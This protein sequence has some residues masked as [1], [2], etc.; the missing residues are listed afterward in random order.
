MPAHAPA[1][2]APRLTA[3]EVRSGRTVTMAA[4][5]ETERGPDDPEPCEHVNAVGAASSVPP[6]VVVMGVSGA[7]K[8][9]VGRL[10]A[11]RLGLPFAEA[12]D[13][14]SAA[15][16]AKMAAG[17]PLDDGDRGPWLLSLAGWIRE[18]AASGRGGVMACSALRREYRDLL[19]RAGAGVV[20][21]HLA[22]DR[23]RA[24][25]RVAGTISCPPR[26]WTPSTPPSNR[27]A[28]TSPA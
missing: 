22:L 25:Q 16:R 18:A 4:R 26:W 19:R 11:D 2:G 7:G 1:A 9:T 12:D 20:F 24:E 21:V 10:L 17:R 6:V 14:H 13:F 5:F 8:S 15:N 23:T 3:A 27:C 28:P